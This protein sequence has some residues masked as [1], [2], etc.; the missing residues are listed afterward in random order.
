MENTK[1]CVISYCL[2]NGIELYISNVNM[3]S[4]EEKELYLT[5]DINLAKHFDEITAEN[6]KIMNWWKNIGEISVKII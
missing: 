6:I 1:K 3:R 5:P 4:K 2:D